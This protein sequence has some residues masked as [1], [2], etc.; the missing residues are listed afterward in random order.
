MIDEK[1]G[2]HKT[3]LMTVTKKLANI[4]ED[5]SGLPINYRENSEIVGFT[6][7]SDS[8]N[9]AVMTLAVDF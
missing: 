6:F 1:K 9:F 8:R 5:L 2:C 4:F 7:E 3:I